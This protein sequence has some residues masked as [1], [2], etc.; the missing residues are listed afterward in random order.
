[1]GPTGQVSDLPR[2][3]VGEHARLS[4]EAMP[5]LA[6]RVDVERRGLLV[7]ERAQ[8]LQR[9]PAGGA[10][11]DVV[12]DDVVDLG[13]LTHLRDV[14]LAYPAGHDRE[15]TAAGRQSSG[16]YHRRSVGTACT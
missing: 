13:L 15:S 9:A 8:A 16:G 14:F 6:S 3:V 11:R 12:R 5:E 10:Q 7:V 1:M 2:T 4:G